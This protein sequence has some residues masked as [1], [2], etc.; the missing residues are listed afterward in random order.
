MPTKEAAW[1]LAL[2]EEAIELCG[3][4]HELRTDNGP[5]FVAIARTMLSRLW[6]S[7]VDLAIRR[8]RTQID[9]AWTNGMH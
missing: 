4:P 1:I 5:P 6:R 7:L 3:V 8:I 9:T 2:F